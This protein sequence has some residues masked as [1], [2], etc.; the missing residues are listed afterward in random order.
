MRPCGQT[1][2]AFPSKRVTSQLPCGHA[3]CRGCLAELRAKA[4]R[5]ECPLCRAELPPGLDGLYDLGYR[6]YSR[7]K[8]MVDRGEA[9]WE[10][11]SAVEMK[12]MS[13]VVAMLTEAAD[14][15][16]ITP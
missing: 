5:H 15:V 4:V 2:P 9:S 3:Y 11:L 7:V 10:S 1:L 12:E 13:E 16:N 6:A 8:G 14:Q